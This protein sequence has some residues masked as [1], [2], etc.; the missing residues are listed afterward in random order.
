MNIGNAAER[1]G[2]PL[3]TIRYYEDIKLIRPLRNSNG[4]RAFRESDIH[5]LTFL[6]RARALGF[7]IEDC[8]SLLA[9]WED[10]DRASAD[11]RKIARKNLKT[12][13]DKISDLV[14]MRETLS[15]LVEACAGD[16]R[17][18]CPI[19]DRLGKLSADTGT[20]SPLRKN[21]GGRLRGSCQKGRQ[22]P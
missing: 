21:K 11:V 19:M 18:D 12:I 14:D 2:L 16:H 17:P 13:E 1:S 3:K 22:R 15:H 10:R 5:K 7:T 8:R 6:G 20:A 9:L 4:Y